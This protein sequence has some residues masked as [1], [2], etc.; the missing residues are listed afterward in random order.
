MKR[1][2]CLLFALFVVFVSQPLAQEAIPPKDT[3]GA[4]E[5]KDSPEWLLN[6]GREQLESKRYDKAIES[7]S[8]A[9]A[10]KPE[11][12]L[13]YHG[14]TMAYLRLGD[15][16]KAQ[17][18]A[19]KAVAVNPNDANAHLALAQ[20]SLAQ[21]QPSA[22]IESYKKVTQLAPDFSNGFYDLG[23]AYLQV[24]KS[25]EAATALKESIRLNPNW[26][27]AHM[28]LAIA[29]LQLKKDD[30]GIAELKEALRV[31]PGAFFA[32]DRLAREG[33]RLGRFDDA[34]QGYAILSTAPLQPQGCQNIAFATLYVGKGGQAAV[35]AQECLQ[36]HGWRDRSDPYVGLFR[37]FGWRQAKEEKQATTA[38]TELQ[39]QLSQRPSQEQWPL[40]VV[41]YLRRD[42]AA[43]ELLKQAG[44]NDEQTE[45]HAYLGYD[46]SL[47]G[48]K[49][50]ALPHLRWVKENGNRNFIEYPLA[51]LELHRLTSASE[52]K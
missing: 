47:Q 5:Q 46:L 30:E 24:G 9:L 2:A 14:L 38:L 6:Q 7:F 33:I 10:Q 16:P 4:V 44:N 32:A 8:K 20:V 39:T 27:G 3:T 50:D 43:E 28:N 22:A 12:I 19:N 36:M 40:P 52:K 25:E 31:A 48:K 45:A 37:Y 13:A 18:T 23:T 41:K 15:L 21:R 1:I 51:V 49:E 29:Y 26:V 42:L 34:L 17:E 35:V 11:M